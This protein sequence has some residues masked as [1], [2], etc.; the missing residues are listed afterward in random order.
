[1]TLTLLSN[2]CLTQSV[3]KSRDMKLRSKCVIKNMTN[4]TTDKQ[5]EP[6]A[7]LTL[8]LFEGGGAIP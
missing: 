6:A 1:M 5:T 3:S 8:N 2:L 7:N 4:I